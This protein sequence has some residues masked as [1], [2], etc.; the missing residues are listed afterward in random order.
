MTAD[1]VKAL[2]H[3]VALGKR[4]GL[5]TGL[6]GGLLGGIPGTFMAAHGDGTALG[7]PLAAAAVTVVVVAALARTL[8]AKL[9][10]R[11]T[12]RGAVAAVL[13][14][15]GLAAT[16][17]LLLGLMIGM[18]AV[19]SG[20]A[21]DNPVLTI[22]GLTVYSYIIGAVPAVL[23]GLVFGGWFQLGADRV[24]SVDQAKSR[25][26]PSLIGEERWLTGSAPGFGS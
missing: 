24:M 7:V 4:A 17:V 9:G 13:G 6:L 8:G 20:G 19:L 14:G 5:V 3:N 12:G 22:L 15:L 21:Q 1:N 16:A 25:E 2:E 11:L 10:A 23:L 26:R 18:V